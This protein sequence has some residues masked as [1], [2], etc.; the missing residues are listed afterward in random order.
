[1]V[2]GPSQSLQLPGLDKSLPLIC[3]Q[4]PRLNHKRGV[5]S[6]HK[7][8]HLKYPAWTM[9]EAVQLDPMGPLLH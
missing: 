8:G 7:K 1:M 9:E 3:Q 2:S 5:Y 4:Q 6:A